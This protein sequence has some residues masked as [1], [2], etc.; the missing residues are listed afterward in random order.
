[1]IRIQK[2]LTVTFRVLLVLG[3]AAS[4]GLSIETFGAASGNLSLI[5]PTA[6]TAGVCSTAY[7]VSSNQKAGQTGTAI[8]LSG[9]GSGSFFTDSAC[10]NS[11]ASVLI[12]YGAKSAAFYFRDSVAQSLALN[13][14]AS[15][16]KSASLSIVVNPAPVPPTVT[17]TSTPLNPT[18]NVNATFSF[19]GSGSSGET[20]SFLCL[21]DG[22][23]QSVCTSPNAYSGLAQGN[24]SFGVVAVNSAGS[25]S[26]A[27]SYAWT[28]NTTPPSAQITSTPLNPTNVINASFS[29]TGSDP[30]GETISFFCQLD[31]GAQSACNSPYAYS[32]LPEGWHSF[33]V[34]AVDLAGNRSTPAAYTWT[35]NTTPPPPAGSLDEFFAGPSASWKSVKDFGARGDGV[36][37]DTAAIQAGLDS[38]KNMATNNWS[39]LYFP[40]GTYRITQQLTTVRTTHHDFL[41][42]EIIGENPETT[43]IV[44]GGAAGGTMFRWSAWYDKVSR[45]TFDGKGLASN[46]IVRAGAFS[47]YSEMSDLIFKDIPGVCLNLGNGEGYGI[48][49]EMILR[50]RFY[51]CTTGVATWDWNTLDIYVWYSYFEDNNVAIHNATGAFHA[52][53]N[54]FVR[55]QTAD[56]RAGVNMVSSVVNNVSLGSKSFAADIQGNVHFQGNKIYGTTDIPLNILDVSPATL[57]DNVI[58]GPDALPQV[59]FRGFQQGADRY[60]GNSNALLAGNTFATNSLWPVRVTQDPFMHGSGASVAVGREIEK[61]KDGD[62]STYS[63][64]G[65]WQA[66]VGYQ[67][68]APLGTQPAIASYALTSSPGGQWGGDG[69]LD[70]ADWGLY[71][72]NDWGSTWTQ[73]DARIG[74]IFSSRSQRKVYSIANPGAYAIYEL[75]VT[76]NFGGSLANQGGWIVVAEFELLDNSGS[77]LV[78]DPASLLT[79]ADEFWDKMYVDQQTVV[80]PA[81]L[82]IPASLQ[83]WDFAPMRSATVIEVTSFNGAAIQAAINQAAAMPFGSNPVVHLPKGDYSVTSTIIVPSQTPMSI[84]GDGASEHGSR[85]NW[86]GVGSGPVLSLWGPSRTSLRDLNINGG[87]TDGADGLMIDRADQQGGRVFG[88]QVGAYGAGGSHMVDLAFDIN[89]IDQADVNIIASGFGSFWNGVRATGGPLR[90]S[91]QSTAGRTSFLTGASSAG[92]RNFDVRT[93]AALVATAYWY[94]GDWAYAAPLIDLASTSSGS[95]ALSSMSFA[96]QDPYPMIRTQDFSGKLTLLGSN[97][98]AV[99]ATSCSQVMSFN[100]IGTTANIFGAGNSL[101]SAVPVNSLSGIDQTNPQG[102]VSLIT[103]GYSYFPPMTN[104]TIGAEPAANFVE[105]QLQLMRNLNTTPAVVGPSNVTD[106]KLFRVIIGGGDNGTAVRINGQ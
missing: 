57:I 98:N 15:G 60:H 53:E 71:G 91:G 7:T 67:W 103:T 90:S 77:N 27:A 10:G 99:L 3:L 28:I 84:I 31:G 70:P 51:R 65:M 101:P 40:A 56:L 34:I 89:G 47:T 92:N 78:P 100:A 87:N 24:H 39:V 48:A 11:A 32:G 61:V 106:V 46:G 12:P 33:N 86:S 9:G 36:A 83:P 73:L 16:Y 25:Q 26:T 104:K 58:Q 37:D 69:L 96:S 105:N 38:L 44:W 88:Y 18:N 76:K 52:Y 35:I 21:L 81:L 4:G 19:A 43:S 13:A 30:A 80:S 8:T 59:L 54:R 74:E 82:Q 5:G 14:S 1:M 29:F 22:G 49:E 64:A 75:R 68:N 63:V 6:L 20:V 93:G 72:S 95:L 102:S 97:L 85:F 94:E 50:N 55:S 45:L 23:T 17:I 66:M 62:P 79:G 42:S 2:L 41:G